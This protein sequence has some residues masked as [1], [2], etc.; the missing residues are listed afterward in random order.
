MN[1]HLLADYERNRSLNSLA[2]TTWRQL[3]E[4]NVAGGQRGIGR[5]G[6]DFWSVIK[7]SRGRRQGQVWA[8]YP[9]SS[10]RNLDIY[11]AVLAPGPDGPVATTRY[12]IFR[13]GIQECEARIFIEAAMADESLAEKLG[14]ALIAR[15]E[16]V[17]I[18]RISPMFR[19]QSN[20][21]LD[22]H[23][24]DFATSWRASD[25]IAGHTWFVGS[26]WQERSWKLYELAGEV[27]KKLE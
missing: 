13:E 5:I 19:G 9:Q 16:K 22:G 14:P 2:G 1:R 24:W 4:Y 15:C 26:G 10:R 3:G 21:Q 11:T 12:E 20:L 8:R 6:A 17:L 25:G 23:S 27:A 7:D 18:A